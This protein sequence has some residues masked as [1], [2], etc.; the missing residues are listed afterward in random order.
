MSGELRQNILYKL[1]KEIFKRC[2]GKNSL[3]Q[4]EIINYRAVTQ[5]SK[6]QNLIN[7]RSWN[8][9]YCHPS[10]ISS[11]PHSL[12]GICVNGKAPSFFVKREAKINLQMHCRDIEGYWTSL[13]WIAFLQP[14][15]D[16]LAW[17]KVGSQVQWC[18]DNFQP[19]GRFWMPG[20]T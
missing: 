18:K 6:R 9:C 14:T 20:L 16:F 8:V 19:V 3:Y 13:L 2:R 5:L 15:M 10:E 1:Q 4:Q 17:F 7:W 11:I 12:G